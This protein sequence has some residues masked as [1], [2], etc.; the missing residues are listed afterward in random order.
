MPL[1]SSNLNSLMLYIHDSINNYSNILSEDITYPPNGELTDAEKEELKKLSNNPVL[2][3]A[4]KKIT[5]DAA[6]AVTF[7]IFCLIDGVTDPTNEWT[8]IKLE[9]INENEEHES[10]EMLHDKFYDT[11]Y[12]WKN[13]NK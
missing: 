11:F 6:A 5:A 8:G 4:F 3:S 13:N 2:K 12:E 7:D 10:E 9:D 1:S